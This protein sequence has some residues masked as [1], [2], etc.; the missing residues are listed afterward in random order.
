MGESGHGAYGDAEREPTAQPYLRLHDA[1]RGDYPRGDR[2]A[3]SCD[4]PVRQR[5]ELVV[6]GVSPTGFVAL[7]QQQ[8]VANIT[9]ALLANVDPG[10]DTS[11][12]QPIGQLIGI[13]ANELASLWELGATAY[14]GFDP[15]ASEGQLLVALAS[16]TGTIP[17]PP[18]PSQ[19]TCNMT[20]ASSSSIPAGSVANVAG[21]PTNT[22]TL[23]GP[24]DV[25][26][27]PVPGPVVST[28]AGT[29]QGV[30]QSTQTGPIVANS[31]TLTVIT[32]P[33]SGWSAVTN[34]LDAVLGSLG[35]DPNLTGSSTELRQKREAELA[36]PGACTVDAIQAALDQL[37]GMISCS[38]PENTTMFTDGNNQPA[39]SFQ[40][41][42]WDGV[43]PAV[44]NNSIAQT[45]WDDKPSGIQAYGTLTGT[46]TDASGNSHT[47][48]F[49][50]VTVVDL[51]VDV[52]TTPNSLTTDQANAVK[53]AIVA[54]GQQD[55]VPGAEVVIL[56]VR[57]SAIVPG[58]TIDVPTC[59]VDTVYPP[60]NT[61]NI[62]GSPFTVYLLDTSR[63]LVNGI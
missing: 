28:S 54:Y 8:I 5:W 59:E 7:T 14:N 45:I 40:A 53:A 35:D 52:T 42:I 56:G 20:L 23:V 61:A 3:F 13:I 27:N 62:S 22:W 30:F 47:V 36:A 25:D 63:I 24:P 29:Y 49:T 55:L 50:R 18:T 39:K 21:Q 16:L 15:D 34:P 2:G 4:D 26:G 46:A 38:V 17:D 57:A 51:Y 9:T 41:L 48:S 44:P 37:A 31:G 6:S 11:P 12:D 33:V 10:L 43:S 32:A 58:I 60:V 19:V 1:K